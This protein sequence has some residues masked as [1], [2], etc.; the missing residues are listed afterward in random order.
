MVFTG[1]CDL[2]GESMPEMGKD[3]LSI[4]IDPLLASRFVYLSV[5]GSKNNFPF[6]A[7]TILY[8]KTAKQVFSRF[9]SEAN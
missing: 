3:A 8:K 5:G 1:F 2:C 9:W 4:V 7:D 6:Y